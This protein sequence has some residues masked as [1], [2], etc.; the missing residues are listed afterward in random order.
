MSLT[1]AE[2]RLIRKG[3][4]EGEPRNFNQ[5]GWEG[6]SQAAPK[7][8]AGR[9]GGGSLAPLRASL[10]GKAGDSPSHVVPLLILGTKFID[11]ITSIQIRFPYLKETG[12]PPNQGG[13]E[14]LRAHSGK[15]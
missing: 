11:F 12:P 1:L 13:L 4:R 3:G 6:V 2:V 8:G 10:K 5:P 9:G 14:S 15:N 7:W